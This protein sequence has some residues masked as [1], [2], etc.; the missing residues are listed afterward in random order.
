MLTYMMGM[1]YYEENVVYKNHVI[2]PVAMNGLTDS[3]LNAKARKQMGKIFLRRISAERNL[4]LQLC[5]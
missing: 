1:D 5:T 2:H 4:F 3:H